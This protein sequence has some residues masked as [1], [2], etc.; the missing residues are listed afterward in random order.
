M[1]NEELITDDPRLP[2]LPEAPHGGIHTGER[3][4]PE[5]VEM[6][7][8]LYE[9]G[10]NPHAIA[11]EVGSTWKV[12]TALCCPER[13]HK[14]AT[15]EQIQAVRRLRD[16]GADFQDIADEM[17]LKLRVVTAI[18]MSDSDV[19]KALQE[20]RASRALVLEAVSMEATT[21]AIE[22]RLESGKLT[23]AEVANATMIANTMVRDTIGAAPIRVRIEADENVMA[24]M[25]LFGGGAKM[26]PPKAEI[27]EAEMIRQDA[28]INQLESNA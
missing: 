1:M 25:N 14:R 28:R 10:S 3:L 24:A 11:K 17:G 15:P 13:L 22:S 21:R 16:E 7:R 5:K 26:L 23:V 19:V 20:T 9:G 6:I 4:P 27:I 18:A 8:K 2:L 12:V